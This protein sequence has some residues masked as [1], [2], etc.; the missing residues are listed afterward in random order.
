MANSSTRDGASGVSASADR[1]HACTRGSNTA[2]STG[3]SSASATEDPAS[4]CCCWEE[5][6]LPSPPLVP[7]A[8]G[9]GADSSADSYAETSSSSWCMVSET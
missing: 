3:P 9:A 6:A 7:R 2:A 8:T 5:E 4:C 1:S